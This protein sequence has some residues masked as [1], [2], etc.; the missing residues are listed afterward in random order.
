[1][2]GVRRAFGDVV[3][4]DDVDLEV[5]AGEVHALLGENGAG[6]S[7]LMNVLAG[8][9]RPDA[10]T[11]EIDGEPV[12]FRDPRSA[13][14]AGIGMVHQHFQLVPTMSATANV[15]LNDEPVRGPAL[16]DAT[17]MRRVRELSSRFGL[18][19]DPAVRVRDASV[20][21]QQKVEILKVLRGD[22]RVLILDEPTAVLS[23]QEVD[24]LFRFLRDLAAA[25]TAIVL[26]T[27]KLSEALAIADHVTILRGGRVVAT[28]SPA[29]LVPHDLA[30]LM[31]GRDVL[32]EIRRESRSAQGSVL[33]LEGVRAF[34]DRGLEALRGIDL[35]CRAGEI[36]GI[37][38]V[39]GNGQRELVEVV[40]GLRSI[41][42][43][44]LSWEGRRIDVG[45][46]AEQIARGIG[47]IPEDRRQRGL[48][49]DL[50][51]SE[52]LILRRFRDAPFAGGLRLR[53]RAITDNATRI[54]ER[55]AV[56]ARPGQ[57]VR[58]LSGGNQQKVVV[59]RELA[60]SPRLLVAS[61][62]TRGVDVGAM[63]SIYDELLTARRSGAAVLL[64]SF[65]LDELLPL[66]DRVAV[67][68]RGKIVATYA[69]SDVTPALLGLDMTGAS[70]VSG[71]PRSA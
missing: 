29:G 60:S 35:E 67:L 39:D 28:R 2:L 49:M 68:Y 51:L 27:H 10:G 36:V 56:R 1:M 33:R 47:Y 59:G 61:Q 70:T 24:D 16:D 41:S 18:H 31:V 21:T 53:R 19:V 40:T 30:K 15:L 4:N 23:P 45:S 42:E 32:L 57:L 55:S 37:A 71:T 62:P 9:L 48:I 50:D 3:A 17:A 8:Y 14:R 52:N 65:D 11:I 7:T 12:Q 63:Q 5:R 13:L 6:K 34:D 38:G 46:V 43:G 54:L 58:S 26:I 25:G 22:V 66:S 44:T 64:V 20:A 69:A